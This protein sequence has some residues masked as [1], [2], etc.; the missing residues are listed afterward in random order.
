MIISEEC[1]N[2]QKRKED[3][4]HQKRIHNVKR[5]PTEKLLIF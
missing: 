4:S 1:A 5:Y 3:N 2:K